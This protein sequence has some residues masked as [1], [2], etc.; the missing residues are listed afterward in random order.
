M[1]EQA[2]LSHGSLTR[3]SQLTTRLE[4]HW[5][6]ALGETLPKEQFRKPA[7]SSTDE[8]VCYS[9]DS[10]TANLTRV[11]NANSCKLWKSSFC[12]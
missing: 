12:L 10:C 4:S 1:N 9:C 6:W 8:L 11:M 7:L 2:G 3:D 5:E